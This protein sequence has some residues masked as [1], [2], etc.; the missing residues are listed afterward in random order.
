MGSAS[1][2]ALSAATQQLRAAKGITL[3][4]GEQLLAAG[5]W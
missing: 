5:R 1:R 2:V 3:A 4:T